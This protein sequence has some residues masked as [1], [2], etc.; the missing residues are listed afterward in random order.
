MSHKRKVLHGSA[1]NLARV[2]L[3]MLVALVLP[4][5]FV[6]RMASVEYS[7][8]VLILQCSAYIN[9]LDLGLQTAVGKFVAE[10][11]AAGDRVASSRIL[12]NSF[13]I[14]CMSALVGAGTIAIVAWRV[15]QLFRQ[16][17]VGLVGDLRQGILVVGL[18]TVLALPFGAFLAAFT[19]LQRYGFP[20]AL[21]LISKLVSSAALAA[22]VLMHGTLVQLAWLMGICNVAT[23]AG[24][25]WGWRRYAK[26]RVGFAFKL[27]HRETALRLA[28]YGSV[29]SIWTIATLLISGLDVVIVG[30][31]DYKD[32]GYYGIAAAAT[33]FMLV[34]VTSVFGPLLPAVS[35]MGSEKTP[36]QI[37]ALVIKITRWCVLL[38][39]LLGL[40]LFFGAYPLLK[41]WV[42]QSYAIQS[43]L[44]LQVLVL[45]NAIR[46]MGYP[47]ALVVV[48][49]GKQRLATIAAVAEA[50]VNITVSIYLAQRIGAVGVAIGTCVGAL[51]S[52]GVHLTVSMRSTHLTIFLSRRRFVLEAILRPLSCVIP[53]MLLLPFWKRFSVLPARLPWLIIWIFCTCTIAW[54]VGLKSTERR[55]SLQTLLHKRG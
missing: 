40:P 17:P 21:A 42:G 34:L 36:S 23:A 39:C 31:Y 5:L 1:S 37:G 10:Y 33:N 24:Q 15:P 29:L 4:P 2:L 44:F 41:L 45:G 32:T 20:T 52:L 38:L 47:Y 48:A 3:S 7:A 12:S 46:M 22:L 25:L 53:S 19:G 49:T 11:E 30:H 9:L 51:V 26:D 27:I 28:K 54:L 14:L 50:L 16:M 43:V 18:S 35:S 8:W 6:H 55:G 13:V